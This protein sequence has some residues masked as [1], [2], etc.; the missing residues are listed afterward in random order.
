M[1]RSGFLS[2]L[3]IET[4]GAAAWGFKPTLAL[5]I[6]GEPLVPPWS[7]SLR[8]VVERQLFQEPHEVVSVRASGM[9]L[10]PG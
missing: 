6:T 1:V 7:P 4:P 8:A 10:P 3:G 9:S 5:G 2:P